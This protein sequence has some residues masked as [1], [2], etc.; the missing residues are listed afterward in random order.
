MIKKSDKFFNTT[1]ENKEHVKKRV[2]MCE[3]QEERVLE[4]FRKKKKHLTA[5]Q[6][7]EIFGGM[8]TPL[9]SIRRAMTRLKN[10]GVIKKTRLKRGGLYNKPEYFYKLTTAKK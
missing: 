8:V 6:V 7:W 9:T 10:A 5:S 1:N 2:A 3:S 4:I